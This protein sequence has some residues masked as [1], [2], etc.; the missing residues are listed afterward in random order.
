MVAKK[1]IFRTCKLENGSSK[2]SCN[3]WQSLTTIGNHHWHPLFEHKLSQ[4][5]YVTKLRYA[6]QIFT[7]L[8][9]CPK[10][11]FFF[12]RYLRKGLKLTDLVTV[13]I[14]KI[15]TIDNLYTNFKSARVQYVA[16]PRY[17]K[18]MFTSLL[19]C[20]KPRFLSKGS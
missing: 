4:V 15:T 16:K 14:K 5:K 1:T 7:S 19:F 18:R 10:P 8:F 20:P 12:K 11:S 2:W 13:L 17:A 6:K 3:H 9:F